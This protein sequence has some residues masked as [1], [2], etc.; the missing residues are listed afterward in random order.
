MKLANIRAAEKVEEKSFGSSHVMQVIYTDDAGRPQTAY[1]QCKVCG[2]AGRPGGAVVTASL[3]PPA[4][5]TRHSSVCVRVVGES[6]CLGAM[7]YVSV[8]T[9]GRCICALVLK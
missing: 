1:L 8:A 3:P 4:G 5:H 6:V 9:R 7:A 2:G